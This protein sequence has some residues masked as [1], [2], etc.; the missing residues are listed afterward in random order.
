MPVAGLLSHSSSNGPSL[1]ISRG[2]VL[3]DCVGR[4]VDALVTLEAETEEVVVLGDNLAGRA[5]E[6]DLEDG[7]VAAQVVHMEDQVVGEFLAV[8]P[9]DPADTQRSQAELMPRGADRLDA[10]ETEVEDHVG[11]AERG[12]EGTAGPVHVNPDVQAGVGLQLVQGGGTWP[13]P[14]RRRRCRSRRR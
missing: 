12:E 10:G 13:P 1:T 8:S 4:V 11:R 9:Q 2:E 3:A 7:H 14:A 5:G 6:I